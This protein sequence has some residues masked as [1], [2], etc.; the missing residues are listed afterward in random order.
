M[1]VSIPEAIQTSG[2]IWTLYNYSN[3]FS[4]LIYGPSVAESSFTSKE[5]YGNA[6]IVVNKV[7]KGIF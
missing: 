1:C 4:A 5:D 7:A 2:M 6:M 3:C